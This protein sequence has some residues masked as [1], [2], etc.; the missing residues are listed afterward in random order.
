MAAMNIGHADAVALH[1][2]NDARSDRKLLDRRRRLSFVGR[3]RRLRLLRL[4]VLGDLL[5]RRGLLLARGELGELNECVLN[6]VDEVQI[7]LRV[8]DPKRPDRIGQDDRKGRHAIDFLV[9]LDL[10]GEDRRFVPVPADYELLGVTGELVK[11]GQGLDLQI[12]RKLRQRFNAGQAMPKCLVALPQR[13]VQVVDV[14]EQ[15]IAEDA[16]APPAAAAYV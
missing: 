10:L 7:D 12:G 14:G 3:R 15:A 6:R 5:R 9:R 2:H 1:V 4:P 16:G 11:L 8:F 13:P